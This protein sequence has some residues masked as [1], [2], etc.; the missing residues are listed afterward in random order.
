MGSTAM[1]PSYLQ[2][3]AQNLL[4]RAIDT[5][6]HSYP[7]VVERKLDD[8][9]LVEQ[10]RAA[11]MRGLL[12]K[13]HV[14]STAERA[15][16][17]NR[18]YADFRVAGGLVLNDTVGGLN[19][20]AVEA[21]LKLGA[22]QVWMPTLSAANHR[23]HLGG[24]GTLT[25]LDDGHLR[26]EVIE[27][28][29]LL[30]EGDA[31][32]ATGHLSPRE[33]EVLIEAALERGVSR[34]NVTHPEW[35]VTAFPI[36]SQRRFAKTGRV[37]LERCLVATLPGAPAPIPFERIVQEIRGTPI[38]QNIIASDLGMPQFPT[39][40]EGLR[41][42]IGRLLEAGFT[43]DGVCSMCQVNP[44]RLLRWEP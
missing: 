33:T 16:L 5:H 6:V 30:A 13:S 3:T 1:A 44:A 25:V 14:F 28:L 26:P 11:G 21:A 19:P 37:F 39:P 9:E 38:E 27:I 20:R 23:Q 31:I 32:L 12:L 4:R 18:L 8:V 40:V 36:E 41:T 24:G 15:W 43:A 42:F 7:D 35:P 34:I 29:R 22:V 17:L 10:A 2:Q